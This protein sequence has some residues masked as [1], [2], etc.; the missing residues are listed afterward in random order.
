MKFTEDPDAGRRGEFEETP[1]AGWCLGSDVLK[2]KLENF[3]N[4]NTAKDTFRGEQ[5]RDHGIFEAERLIAIS[6]F[7]NSKETDVIKLKS[8]MLQSTA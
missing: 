1:K 2:A 3:I 6:R 7:R 8:K 5:R 4:G